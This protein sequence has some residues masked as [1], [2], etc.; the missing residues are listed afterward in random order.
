MHSRD[1]ERRCPRTLGLRPESLFA[2]RGPMLEIDEVR[3]GLLFSPKRK[4]PGPAVDDIDRCASWHLRF[5][6]ARPRPRWSEQWYEPMVTSTTPI[7]P[8]P[9]ASTER[10]YFT[11]R[12]LSDAR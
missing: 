1:Y 2:R 7:G 12:S 3:H 8:T 11:P 10:G 5:L 6:L 9:L 4:R